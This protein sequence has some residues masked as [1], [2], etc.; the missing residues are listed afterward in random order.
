MA[1]KEGI[2]GPYRTVAEGRD[3]VLLH[4][5]SMMQ[6]L[7][8]TKPNWWTIAAEA[9]QAMEVAREVARGEAIH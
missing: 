2:T 8:R 9:R 4:I 5:E 3:L 7:G 6:E 1:A